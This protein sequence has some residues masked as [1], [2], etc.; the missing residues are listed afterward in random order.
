[1]FELKLSPTVLLPTEP[2]RAGTMKKIM[3]GRFPYTAFKPTNLQDVTLTYTPDIVAM[4]GEARAALATLK[5]RY[6]KLTEEQQQKFRE[7][8]LKAEVTA[9]LQLAVADKNEADFDWL[10]RAVPYAFDE[11]KHLPIS[12]RLLTAVHDM[13]LHD[14]SHYKQNPGEFRRSPIWMG[15]KKATLTKGAD[16]VPPAP[17][18]MTAAFSALEHYIHEENDTEPLVKAALI[19]YQFEMI[20]PFLDGNG[21]V[22]RILTLLCLKEGGLLPAPILPISV[23]LLNQ[24]FYYYAYLLGVEKKGTY[25]VWIKYFVECLLRAAQTALAALRDV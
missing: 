1:M 25:E 19:H 17:E 3:N 4:V 8:M 16:F 24:S 12:H 22:G 11:L 2:A 6:E 20:H 23:S 18:D 21:R 10:S 5:T 9:S 15:K 14:L 7:A 13:A